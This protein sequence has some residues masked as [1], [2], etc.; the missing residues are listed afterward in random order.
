MT[1]T[2]HRYRNQ[3]TLRKWTGWQMPSGTRLVT[4]RTKE[5]TPAASCSSNRKLFQKRSTTFWFQAGLYFRHWCLGVQKTGKDTTTLAAS[6]PDL[7]WFQDHWVHVAMLSTHAG[8]PC[9]VA[10]LG[11]SIP[12]TQSPCRCATRNA[13]MVNNSCQLTCQ[14]NYTIFC[15]CK[16]SII[17]SNVPIILNCSMIFFAHERYFSSSFIN[18]CQDCNACR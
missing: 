2:F 10:R 1:V 16:E 6:R 13:L 15:I 18:L 9:Q 4:T 5:R 3:D 12:P 8:V 17:I 7:V 11:Q 14:T